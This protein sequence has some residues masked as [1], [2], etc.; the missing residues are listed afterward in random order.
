MEPSKKYISSEDLK[1]LNLISKI[2]KLQ[3]S[4]VLNTC[5]EDLQLNGYLPDIDAEQS[6]MFEAVNLEESEDS[7]DYYQKL[8]SHGSLFSLHQPLELLVNTLTN[9]L[10]PT[11]KVKSCSGRASTSSVKNSNSGRTSSLGT[12]PIR[13]KPP[14]AGSV[15]G[16]ASLSTE[17]KQAKRSGVGFFHRTN[18][19][20][21]SRNG[22]FESSSGSDDTSSSTAGDETDDEGILQRNPQNRSQSTKK[23][24][25]ITY[26][27][28]QGRKNTVRNGSLPNRPTQ[29][30]IT[31]RTS[32][33]SIN[34]SLQKPSA[35]LNSLTTKKSVQKAQNAEKAPQREK[36]STTKNINEKKTREKE[37]ATLGI[38]PTLNRIIS[39]PYGRSEPQNYTTEERTN[40]CQEALTLAKNAGGEKEKTQ[41]CF[42][43]TNKKKHSQRNQSKETEPSNK[44]N[45]NNVLMPTATTDGNMNN[46]VNPPLNNSNSYSQNVMPSTSFIHRLTPE[47]EQRQ[48][49]ED[50]AEVLKQHAYPSETHNNQDVS[51]VSTHNQVNERQNSN[52]YLNQRSH[53]EEFSANP[54]AL[55]AVNQP[56]HY[57]QTYQQDNINQ[58]P[59]SQLRIHPS[60]I[61]SLQQQQQQDQQSLPQMLSQST[62]QVQS[63]YLQQIHQRLHHQS[64]P[65]IFSQSTAQ[66]NSGYLQQ[67][68]QHQHQKSPSQMFSHSAS[69]D[70]SVFSQQNQQRSQHLVLQQQHYSP[71]QHLSQPSSQENRG[72]HQQYQ[73]QQSQTPGY[74]QQQQ[75]HYESPP[76]HLSQ[77]A[78]LDNR[79]YHQQQ[80]MVGTSPSF[81]QVSPPQQQHFKAQSMYPQTTY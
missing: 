9:S 44:G 48:L 25:P 49:F 21:Y 13:T 53:V 78:S 29:K 20:F 47:E 46:F 32:A 27:T 80:L 50:A 55:N 10:L 3:N 4:Q 63:G 30:E 38:A 81:K 74:Q 67:I 24:Q 35:S 79:G 41:S 54:V 2:L 62:S 42:S 31:S 1:R 58:R 39:T 15:A 22:G 72:F 33:N 37:I 75:Q 14:T 60:H 8:F 70:N 7:V 5:R 71:P 36:P 16:R 34:K 18:D 61:Q 68:Q 12:A 64:P 51:T 40:E 57:P 23:M 28:A 77:P 11:T 66:S 19:R 17:E 56:E 45:E 26:R 65:Q 6:S 52:Y 73:Q 76:Q 59:N 43:D 69:Q